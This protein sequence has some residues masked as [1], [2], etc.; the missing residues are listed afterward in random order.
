MHSN[1]IEGYKKSLKLT[2]RQREVIV[3]LMLGDGHL[4]SQDKG[5]TYRL[6]VEY[7]A[8]QKE[9]VDWLFK[10]FKDWVRTPPQLKIKIRPSGFVVKTIYF[11]TYS[12]GALRFYGHQFYSK[13]GKKVIP[14]IID[15]LLTPLALAIWFMDDGSWKSENHQ[16]YIIH[17]NGYSRADLLKIQKTLLH[18]FGIETFLHR[19]YKNWRIY[20]KTSSAQRFRSL[21][22]KFIIPSMKYKLGNAE[23]A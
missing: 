19:Q 22:E 7:S 12:H 14:K 11:Q 6:K 10:I 1:I 18:K 16:T 3:G 4:E 13:E 8:T 9:Y 2:K 15:K 5:R 20:V 23:L 21:V 17:V